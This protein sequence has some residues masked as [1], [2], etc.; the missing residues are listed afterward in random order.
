MIS[1]TAFVAPNGSNRQEILDLLKKSMNLFIEHIANFESM[2]PLN[3]KL[4]KSFDAIIPEYPVPIDVIFHELQ[5]V[6]EM[7]MNP[8]HPGYMGHMDSMATTMS[9]VGD[10]I[11]AALNNNML[12]IEMSPVLSR[13]E[14]AVTKEVAG[15]FGLGKNAGGALTSGGTLANLQALTVARNFTFKS[16]QRGM[17]GFPYQPVILASEVAHTSLQKAAMILGLGTESIVRVSVKEDSQLNVDDLEDQIKQCRLEGKYPF[18]VVATAGTTITGSVDNLIA[19]NKIAKEQSLWFHVDAAYGGGLIFSEQHKSLLN[20]IEFADSVTFNPQKFL[21][22][23]KTC[24]MVL[25]RN[26][27]LFQENFR[28]VAPYMEEI[29]NI[30]LGEISV[31]GT[32]H[33]DILKFWLS[34][35]HIGKCGYNELVDKTFQLTDYFMSHVKKRAYL[36]VTNVPQTNVICFRAIPGWLSEENCDAWNMQLQM[37]LLEAGNTYFSL[38]TYRNQHWLRVVLLNPYIN[39][40]MI[41]NLFAKIDEFYKMAYGKYKI[42]ENRV[43]SARKTCWIEK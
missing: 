14:I 7:S 36:S 9:I 4:E 15:L 33:A 20:G 18:C 39:E 30:N 43:N 5:D 22:I 10:M 13:L 26:K 19:I 42:Q 11:A 8:S 17:V 3:N 23:A 31:Q 29:P 1:K 28:I 38:Q 37:Y 35:Q 12:S 34:L 32:R 40:T 27:S 16:L 21:Y 24:S 6:I 2:S 41:D 25:F